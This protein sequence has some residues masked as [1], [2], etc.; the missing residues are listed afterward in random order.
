M[1]VSID[2][3]I[4]LYKDVFS[5]DIDETSTLNLEEM[6][7]LLCLTFLY[8]LK[9]LNPVCSIKMIK[10]YDI[11]TIADLYNIMISV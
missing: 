5:V 8:K 9:Q 4:A 6:D 3:L 7:S 1:N 11:T 2:E 10:L